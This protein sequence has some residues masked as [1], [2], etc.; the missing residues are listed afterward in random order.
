M[1]EK[2]LPTIISPVN[3]APPPTAVTPT[4]A[5]PAT[6]GVTL[7]SLKNLKKNT[8][9][10]LQADAENKKLIEINA[11]NLIQAW[12][13]VVENIA[14]HKMLYK[15]AILQSEVKFEGHDITIHANLVAFDFIKSERLQLLNFFKKYYGNE[16][17]NVLFA[18][19]PEKESGETKVLSTR[20]IFEKMATKNPSLRML[21]DSL[22]L[23]FEY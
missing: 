12:H 13:E 1:L 21:K 10:K 14:S 6:Y 2:T 18:V 9:D 15:S 4:S 8:R 22:G 3:V 5:A 7:S 19:L 16:N 11:M 20:E 23:D 17:I